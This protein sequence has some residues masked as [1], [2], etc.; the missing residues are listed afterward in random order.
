MPQGSK[1]HIPS[2][3]FRDTHP[4]LTKSYPENTVGGNQTS[5]EWSLV[6]TEPRQ[7]NDLLDLS[8]TGF[9]PP[10]DDSKVSQ[11]NQNSP[12]VWNPL[13]GTNVRNVVSSAVLGAK[14]YSHV[15]LEH[16]VPWG[17]GAK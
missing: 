16:G 6:A 14:F 3:T 10:V 4:A 12:L 1:I 9:S 17:E 15:K 8:V 2:L 11:T 5:S 13:L 7:F